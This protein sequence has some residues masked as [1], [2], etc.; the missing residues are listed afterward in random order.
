MYWRDDD[1][2]DGWRGIYAAVCDWMKDW[3]DRRMSLGISSSERGRIV[4]CSSRLSLV[5]PCLLLWIDIDCG[6]SEVMA[7]R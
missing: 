6:A 2:S 1:W 7:P 4:D 5:V 3:R